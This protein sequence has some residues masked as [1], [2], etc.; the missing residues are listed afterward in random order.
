MITSYLLKCTFIATH[1]APYA[2]KCIGHVWPYL[3][4]TMGSVI[5]IRA[6]QGLAGSVHNFGALA[7]K[8]IKNPA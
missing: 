6:G 7:P 4:R 1:T 8:N 3:S 5:L 2:P